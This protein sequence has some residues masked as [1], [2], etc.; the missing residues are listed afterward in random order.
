MNGLSQSHPGFSIGPI[1]D[2]FRAAV[3]ASGQQAPI[4]S[5]GGTRPFLKGVQWRRMLVAPEAGR[6]EIAVRGEGAARV[7]SAGILSQETD[8]FSVR[9]TIHH[10]VHA[11]PLQRLVA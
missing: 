8:P 7:P 1:P 2:I 5:S 10:E 4:R 6:A 11:P 3:G 9:I